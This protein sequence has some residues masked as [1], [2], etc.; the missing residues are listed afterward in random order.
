[1]KGSLGDTRS[2]Q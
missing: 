1:L 2:L